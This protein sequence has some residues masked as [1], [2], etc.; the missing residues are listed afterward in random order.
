MGGKPLWSHKSR[1]DHSGGSIFLIILNATHS[2]RRHAF[3]I[4]VKFY[5]K[6]ANVHFSLYMTYEHRKTV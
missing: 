6:N 3:K 5:I 2:D 4:F 1:D